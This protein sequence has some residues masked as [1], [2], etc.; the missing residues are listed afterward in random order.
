[1]PRHHASGQAP[2]SARPVYNSMDFDKET[3][4]P[5][6]NT[7]VHEK[8]SEKKSKDKNKKRKK[9]SLDAKGDKQKAKAVSA[10]V[11]PEVVTTPASARSKNKI[12]KDKKIER[13]AHEVGTSTQKRKRQNTAQADVATTNGS[14]QRHTGLLNGPKF[15][16]ELKSSMGNLSASFGS[17]QGVAKSADR[18]AKKQKKASRKR[19][20]G[21]ATIETIKTISDNTASET[22]SKK[23]KEKGNAHSNILAAA[24]PEKTPVPVPMAN[25]PANTLVPVPGTRPRET[26]TPMRTP[27]PLPQ[28]SL[29]QRQEHAALPPQKQNDAAHA[30]LQVLV[31]ETPPSHISRTT[32]SVSKTPIPFKLNQTTNTPTAS[33]KKTTK[34]ATIDISPPDSIDMHEISSSAPTNNINSSS[35]KTLLTSSNLLQY[36]QALNDEPKS[37]PRGRSSSIATSTVSSDSNRNIKEMLTR[38]NK[39]YTRSGAEIDPFVVP[40]AKKKDK[41]KT[42]KHQETHDEA[43]LQTFT[44]AFSAVQKTVNFTDE[45]EYLTAYNAYKALNNDAGPLPC[46]NRATGCNSKREQVLRLS[47]EDASPIIT[48]NTASAADTLRLSTATSSSEAAERL[49]TLA[50]ASRV[51]IPLGRITGVW[52]LYCPSYAATHIDMYA[53]GQRTLSISSIA[54]FASPSAYTARL[55]LPPR[56]M[57]FTIRAFEAPPHASFR[58]TTLRTAPEGYG[59]DVVFLGNGYLKAWIDLQELLMGKKMEGM[60]GGGERKME[61][62]GVREGATAWVEEVD[63][64]EIEGRRLCRAYDGE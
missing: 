55:S 11:T 15:L 61:F 51:P 56:S 59:F 45:Q 9:H 44:S 40:F 21:H 35:G 26:S 52:T 47:K 34:G 64:L 41:H 38:V 28:K 31:P 8:D 24:S 19:E 12:R 60:G 2:P 27:I 46:L 63:E 42:K 20:G 48:V 17:P 18:P 57:A 39:P 1:M 50:V 10:P 32:T 37:R 3:P 25:S 16:E 36:K 4:E 54:G 5:V 22:T 7:Q 29:F 6:A 14:D 43:D 13:D 49:L 62:W 58:S 23:G 53:F 33:R 30:K